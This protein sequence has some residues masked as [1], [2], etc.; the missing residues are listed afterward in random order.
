MLFSLCVSLWVTVCLWLSLH[1][2]TPKSYIFMLAGYS[3]AIMGFPDVESPLAIIN[4]VVSRIEEITLGILCSTL[5]HRL[6]FPVSMHHL[7]GQSVNL[8]FQNARNS[9]M[10]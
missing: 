5:V 10:N 9:V 1:D 8:W 4:T 2:R 6:V 7:L 3:A